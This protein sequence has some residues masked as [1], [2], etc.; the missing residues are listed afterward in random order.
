MD[1][2]KGLEKYQKV[3]LQKLAKLSIEEEKKITED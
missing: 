1:A 3:Y 2:Q